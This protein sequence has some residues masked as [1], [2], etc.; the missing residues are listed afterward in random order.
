MTSRGGAYLVPVK[1]Q[2]QLGFTL[3]E[4]LVVV[5]ILSI[6]AGMISLSVG[7]S[8]SRKNRAFYEHLIDSLQYVRLLS[9]ERMQPMGLTLKADQQGQ[10]TPVIMTLNNPYS[11]YQQPQAN[12]GGGQ[13]DAA[14]N[15]M[16]L[17]GMSAT[18][19]KADLPTWE[20]EPEV[21]LPIPPDKVTIKISALGATMAARGSQG[22]EVARPL[23]PWF[24][25]QDVP[26]VIW[27]GTGEATPVT[28]EVLY[29]SKPIGEAILIEPNGSIK[30]GQSS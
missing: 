3:V 12:S 17:S 15:S 29:D 26:Q 5:V 25:G 21:T 22:F 8:E 10:I 14:K 18:Q 9:A 23:Q 7:S 1:R 24:L 16:E 27:F 20:S 30:V 19:D 28:I 4:I 6:F 2:S 13:N 11:A